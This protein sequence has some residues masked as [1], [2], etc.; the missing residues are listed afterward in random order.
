MEHVENPIYDLRTNLAYSATSTPQK[1]LDDN[2]NFAA[3]LQLLSTPFNDISSTRSL[4]TSFKE[5]C[6]SVE[7]GKKKEEDIIAVRKPQISDDENE[8]ESLA[9]LSDDAAAHPSTL[10]NEPD[11]TTPSKGENTKDEVGSVM[12][13]KCADLGLKKDAGSTDDDMADSGTPSY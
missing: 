2:N 13:L 3:S 9:V 4:S 5:R 10:K 6:Q 7:G 1:M 8:W 11:K 12:P